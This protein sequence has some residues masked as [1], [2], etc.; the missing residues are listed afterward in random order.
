MKSDN[1]SKGGPDI[2]EKL[3]KISA[4]IAARGHAN[5]NWDLLLVEQAPS[6]L[7]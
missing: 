7:I 3:L 4:E 1:N 5:L 2:P 6:E